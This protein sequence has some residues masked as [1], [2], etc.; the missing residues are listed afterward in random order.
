MWPYVRVVFSAVLAAA[1]MEGAAWAGNDG[2]GD[3]DKATEAKLGAR[4]LSDLG[5]V[6]KLCESALNKGLDEENTVFAKSLLGS[7]LVERAS[8]A[9]RVVFRDG[10]PNALWP[11]FRKLALDDLNRALAVVPEQPDALVLSARLN[12]L[13]GGDKKA[14]IAALDNVLAMKTE[15]PD[16]RAEALVLRAGTSEDAKRQEDMLDEAVKLSPGSADAVRARGICHADHRRPEK[17]AADLQKALELAPDHAATYEVL[18]MVQGELKQYDRAMVSLD[19]A[20]QLRPDSV[21][22]LSIRAQLHAQQ[23]N[24]EAAL[25][26]L[27]EAH[28][29]QPKNVIVLLLRSALH[30]EMGKPQEALADV[31]EAL[32]IDPEFDR[33]RRL[34]AALLANAGKL[35]E[36]IGELERVV[37]TAPEDLSI[38]IQLAMYYNAGKQPQKAIEI[39]DAVLKE[40]PDSMDALEGRGNAMLGIGRHAEAIADFE[41]AV[42]IKPDEP[43]L[44]NNF[45]WVLATSPD[46]DLR[47]GRRAVELAARACEAT[48]Y[49]EAHILSTLAAA[50]AETGDF[51]AALKWAAKAVELGKEQSPLDVQ[52]SLADELESFRQKKPW[53]ERLHEGLDPG[54]EKK[55]ENAAKTESATPDK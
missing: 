5:E 27:N 34:R 7:T 38:K 44:L 33:A 48:G 25:L 24:L 1:L 15:M 52:K 28:S 23:K 13:P 42:K 30:Q 55:P 36:V 2:Q 12:L 16:L 6:I 9:C 8:I 35:D 41:K 17:A 18:A 10:P 53:R 43:S 3:L 14:A 47:D 39:Y 40:K 20:R 45:A 49:K 26:D 19:K 37:K 31:D 50:H 4:Q 54:G 51:D 11:E 46:D 32:K 21:T 22:P 29:M